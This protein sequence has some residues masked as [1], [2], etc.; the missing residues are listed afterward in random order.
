MK[1]YFQILKALKNI[2]EFTRS[3]REPLDLKKKQILNYMIYLIL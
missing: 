2:N 1:F 3:I